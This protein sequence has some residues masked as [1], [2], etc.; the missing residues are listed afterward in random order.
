M[1]DL[2]DVGPLLELTTEKLD[3]TSELLV[4]FIFRVI[5]WRVF[6]P[7]KVL[8]SWI[9]VSLQ[10]ILAAVSHLLCKGIGRN[11]YFGSSLTYGRIVQSALQFA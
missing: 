4:K 1:L 10:R 3:D 2:C 7:L 6:P 11:C 8:K 5:L 9:S